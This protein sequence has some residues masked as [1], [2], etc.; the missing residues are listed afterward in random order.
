MIMEFDLSQ[1][2]QGHVASWRPRRTNSGIPALV[3]RPE[4]QED[5]WSSF[6]LRNSSLEKQEVMIF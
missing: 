3:W 4:N 5:R 1:S 6:S 2:L